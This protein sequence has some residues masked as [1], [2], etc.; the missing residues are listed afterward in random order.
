[1]DA[2]VLINAHYEKASVQYI[3]SILACHQIRASLLTLSPF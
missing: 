3:E 2:I 1:V